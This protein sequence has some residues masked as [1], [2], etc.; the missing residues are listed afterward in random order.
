MG[1]PF[2]HGK[3]ELS[4]D[5]HPVYPLT[6]EGTSI[7]LSTEQRRLDITKSKN[8]AAVCI[9]TMP[10]GYARFREVHGLREWWEM[11]Q[12]NIA[13]HLG[14]THKV[15][16]V[17]SKRTT[18]QYANCY[19]NHNIQRTSIDIT[20]SSIMSPSTMEF[21]AGGQMCE[22]DKKFGFSFGSYEPDLPD[23]VF[24][25]ARL[26]A[27]APPVP[28][29]FARALLNLLHPDDERMSP[30]KSID[31]TLSNPVFSN[32]NTNDPMTASLND[33]ENSSRITLR[34][35]PEETPFFEPHGAL[36][37]EDLDLP[38]VTLLSDSG[39]GESS[40]VLSHRHH[41]ANFRYLTED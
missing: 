38:H 11:Y 5:Y 37:M 23:W 7:R 1:I 4:W 41:I 20:A 36:S 39:P 19:V 30:E 10:T 2:F 14:T 32:T 9:P 3:Q 15:F 17:V 28:F 18:P 26:K 31:P 16:L 13:H 21:L 24:F 6:S 8:E 40:E 25:I 29:K 22:V 33:I 12:Q 34:D 35:S 27:K